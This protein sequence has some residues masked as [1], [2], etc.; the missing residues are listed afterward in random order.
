MKTSIDAK[1]LA[2]AA[3]RVAG[4][5]E[6]ADYESDQRNDI[7]CFYCGHPKVEHTLPHD[8][9][10][11]PKCIGWVGQG[12]SCECYKWKPMPRWEYEKVIADEAEWIGEI[13][14]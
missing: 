3:K 13:K 1:W 10:P 5:G 11:S 9:S 12:F 6:P 8:L 2:Q 7:V 4:L 14:G